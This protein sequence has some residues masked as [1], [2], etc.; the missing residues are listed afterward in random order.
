VGI[1]VLGTIAVFSCGGGFN[2]MAGQG[3]FVPALEAAF[4]TAGKCGAKKGGYN[5]KQ[6]KT[7]LWVLYAKFAV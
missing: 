1:N 2:T 6:G 4:Y 7:L 3:F 5:S